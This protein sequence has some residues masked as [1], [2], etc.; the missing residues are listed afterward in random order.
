ML[1]FW[2]EAVGSQSHEHTPT[3]STGMGIVVIAYIRPITIDRGASHW[4]QQNKARP[5]HRIMS[6]HEN[7]SKGSYVGVFIIS[8]WRV[9]LAIF[10]RSVLFT[11]NPQC[12]V[13]VKYCKTTVL[14]GCV[15]IVGTCFRRDY[16]RLSIKN[17]ECS[18]P[19]FLLSRS[20][21]K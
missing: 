8:P 15:P 11:E 19:I 17:K 14:R 3:S 16:K 13:E 1:Q 20:G 18:V 9:V 6:V 10:W 5:I 7:V 2:G 4:Q 21:I 12:Y